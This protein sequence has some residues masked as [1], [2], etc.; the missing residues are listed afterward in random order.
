MGT[1]VFSLCALT[2]AVL[3]L[4]AGMTWQRLL[5]WSGE[6]LLVIGVL[7]AAKGISD[8]RREWTLR[9]GIWGKIGEIRAHAVA[10]LWACWNWV[11]KWT[12][13]ARC[14]HLHLT[15]PAR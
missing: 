1:I 15:A 4:A 5:H 7:L 8:V 12:W 9:P 13:L 14:L 11:V 6:L 2:Y 10:F 3:S